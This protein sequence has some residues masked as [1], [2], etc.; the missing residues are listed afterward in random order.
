MSKKTISLTFLS[1]LFLVSSAQ[2]Y[3]AEVIEQKTSIELKNNRLVANVSWEIQINNRSGE[4]LTKVAI[5]YSKI[6]KLKDIEACLKDKTGKV[7]R[8]LSSADITERSAIS[9]FSFYE[10]DFVKE[11]TLKHNDYPYTL[12]YSYTLTENQFVVL[13]N[14]IPVIKPEYPTHK[15]TLTIVVPKNYPIAFRSNKIQSNSIDSTETEITYIWKASYEK[16]ID[17]EYCAPSIY[18]FIPS[19]KVVPEK[20]IFE[21]EGSQKSW[22][23]FGNWQYQLCEPLS[24]LPQTEKD[25]ITSLITG[26]QDKKEIV[27]TLYHYLQ[28]NTRYINISIETGGWKPYPASY[29]AVNKYGDCKALANY[30]KSILA[31][32]NIPSFYVLVNSGN[33]ITYIDKGF[34]ATQFDHAITIVPLPNDTLWLD[35][36]SNMAF[37]YTGTFDQNR[38]ALV[39]KKDSSRFYKIPGLGKN[40]TC[41]IRSIQIEADIALKAKVAF[42]NLYRG[43]KYEMLFSV[44]KNYNETQRQ[45]ILHDEFTESGFSNFENLK[46]T[47]YHRDSALMGLSYLATSTKLFR[48]YGNEV[49]TD[50]IPFYLPNFEKPENRQLPV[51][52]DY[53]IYKID[54]LKYSFPNG[55]KL[56][57]IFPE[58]K[59]E[60]KYGHCSIKAEISPNNVTVVKKIL[61]FPGTYPLSEYGDFYKFITKIKSIENNSHLIFKK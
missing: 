14:W 45:Q 36:T 40:Q 8:K 35:C 1:L 13:D 33:Q 38:D 52:I 43:Y 51:Q 34:T 9:S 30:F 39:I 3:N 7:V 5:P 57:A 20:F 15:A 41:E 2:K 54:T 29:V 31:Y 27:K 19:V 42:K 58:Q 28:D 47:K 37:N 6:V 23:E 21:I 46:L 59:I 32:V 48:D 22:V 53:P 24:E 61:I 12:F 18:T 10:D 56:S 50:M 44:D 26:I 25:K 49:I 17:P 16:I 60:E 4:K 55:F 11:F